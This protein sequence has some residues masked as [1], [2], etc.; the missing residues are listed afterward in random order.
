MHNVYFLPGYEMMNRLV[1]RFAIGNEDGHVI[2]TESVKMRRKVFENLL[3][4]TAQELNVW[5]QPLRDEYANIVNGG[6][7]ATPQPNVATTFL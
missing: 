7:N 2:E 6:H 5:N 4:F 3:R 1:N